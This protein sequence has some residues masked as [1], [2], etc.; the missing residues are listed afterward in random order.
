MNCLRYRW[1]DSGL[2]K[3]ILP[4]IIEEM[5]ERNSRPVVPAKDPDVLDKVLKTQKLEGRKSSPKV[6]G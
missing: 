3:G 5:S 2:L 1:E 4:S 6:D